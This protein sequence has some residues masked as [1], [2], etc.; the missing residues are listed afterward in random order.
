M[1]MK[2]TVK[3]LNTVAIIANTTVCGMEYR[4]PGGSSSVILLFTCISLAYVLPISVVF[5]VNSVIRVVLAVVIKEIVSIVVDVECKAATKNKKRRKKTYTQTNQ[6]VCYFLL[7][8]CIW[9]T[10]KKN[11]FSS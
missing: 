3:I 5:T 6:S 8:C 2:F 11:T 10:Y 4:N 9:K 7:V 1:K